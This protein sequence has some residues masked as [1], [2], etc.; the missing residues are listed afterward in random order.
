MKVPM[1]KITISYDDEKKVFIPELQHTEVSEKLSR[2]EQVEII[3]Q[4]VTVITKAI[5]STP[6]AGE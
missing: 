5:K 3:E 6:K 2:R 1:F 4:C